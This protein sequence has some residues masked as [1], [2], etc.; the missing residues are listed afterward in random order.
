MARAVGASLAEAKLGKADQGA[1]ALCRRYARLIDNAAPAAKYR[2]SLE[3][4][5]RALD[6]LAVLDPVVGVDYMKHWAK[7][8]DALAEHTVA[9][10]LGPKLLVALTSLGLTLA[11]RGAKGGT[12]GDGAPARPASTTDRL[13]EQR[14]KRAQRAGAD[15]A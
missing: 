7:I 2:E 12:T 11:G 5:Q 14:E 8:T 9:S 13:R 10:D 6:T 1:A 15:G 3:A 4:V